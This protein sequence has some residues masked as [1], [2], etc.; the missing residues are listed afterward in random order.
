MII[1]STK[2]GYASKYMY[3]ITSKDGTCHSLVSKDH[4]KYLGA[5]IDE[6]ISWKHHTAGA[7]ARLAP[8]Y[9]SHFAVKTLIAS[10]CKVYEKLDERDNGGESS[11]DSVPRLVELWP[12]HVYDPNRP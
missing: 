1:K 12:F 10:G 7:M 11:Y 9:C 8:L 4:I 2:K 5:M 3:S 6:C